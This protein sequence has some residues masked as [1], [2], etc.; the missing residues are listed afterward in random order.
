MVYPGTEAYE[1][2]RRNGYLTTEDFREW[3]TPDG[4][5]RTVLDQPGLMAEE[6]ITWCDQA[7]RSFYL[8][9]RY[10]AAK[11]WQ[12][13]THPA[14]AGRISRAVRVFSRYLFRPSLPAKSS[15]LQIKG[16]QTSEVSKR[17]E[18]TESELISGQ[19][20]FRRPIPRLPKSHLKGLAVK[21]DSSTRRKVS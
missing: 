15:T 5:H 1:W 9:P 11:M 8:R 21:S 18:L 13:L 3:L 7:R 17:L 4:L 6:L 20:R 2:A 19:F 12:I 10:V 14:E 16:A